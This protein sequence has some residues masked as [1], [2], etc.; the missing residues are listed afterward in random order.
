MGTVAEQL[1][2]ATRE[3]L[4]EAFLA[5]VS[6]V[7]ERDRKI[8]AQA[9]QIEQ[10]QHQVAQLQKMI[11]GA[12]SEKSR[13]LY[14]DHPTLFDVP[15]TEP[16]SEVETEEI[17]VQRKKPAAPQSMPA[18]KP[19]P[20]HLPRRKKIIEPEGLPEDAVRIGEKVTEVLEMEPAKLW[21]RRIVRP[22]YRLA[23]ETIVTA[24]MPDRWKD[25]SQAG[26]SIVAHIITAKF[27]DH[28]PT[29]RQVQMFAREGY[30]L[31]ESTLNQ[32][33]RE[34]ALILAPLFHAMQAAVL[35]QRYLQ[36]DETTIRVLPERGKDKKNLK[37]GTYLGYFWV[38]RSPELGLPIFVYQ[39]GRGQECPK[40]VLESF[41]GVLQTDGYQA[42]DAVARDAGG[43][44]ELAGCWAHARRNFVEAE[45]S[46]PKMVAVI[47]RGI[48]LLYTIEKQI[49]ETNASPEEVLRLRARARNLLK[50]ARPKLETLLAGVRPK[51]PLRKAIEY[52]LKRW[53]KLLLYTER[54]ELE[55]DNN[56]IE[57]AI[58]PVAV[59]RKNYLFAGSHDSAQRIAMIYSFM[60]ACKIHGVN[61]TEWL[62]DV[63]V[64]LPSTKP[65]AYH[66]LFPSN[67]T[68]TVDRYEGLSEE[69]LLDEVI[70]EAA[71]LP[72]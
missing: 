40:D 49:R 36:A 8:A 64:K 43:R 28:L 2:N 25:R 56:A 22:T 45:K 48:G 44:I 57:N 16:E 14:P 6:S 21:V 63:L 24:E 34:A 35:I 72:E 51:K 67:W 12:R 13:T 15:P 38:Y 58:R 27:C 32:M 61:P 33:I 3:E 39:P 37:S 46:D 17:V 18:R 54:P 5:A 55:I 50:R 10:L 68:K 47:L 20:G 41:S 69:Y 62:A 19:L 70:A 23:D 11:F 1:E 42:Y 65:S 66:T 26:E 29:Y 53:D 59:G 31:S 4:I 71:E 7:Q 30:K 60:A 9:E 52:T